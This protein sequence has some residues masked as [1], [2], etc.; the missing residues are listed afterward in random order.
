[1]LKPSGGAR[2]ARIGGSICPPG[3]GFPS[4]S[5]GFARNDLSRPFHCRLL[6]G[7]DHGLMDSVLGRKLR[8]GLFAAAVGL[9]PRCID[10]HK[11]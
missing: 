2:R 7:V 10:E 8:G 1:M 9:A 3:N 4:L 5:L 6:P 11:F